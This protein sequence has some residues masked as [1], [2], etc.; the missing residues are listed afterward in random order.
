MEECDRQ[1]TKKIKYIYT[2]Q[3]I[4]LSMIHSMLF[5]VNECDRNHI[6][7]YMSEQIKSHI[8]RLYA[9]YKD[10]TSADNY[11]YHFLMKDKEES[12]PSNFDVRKL[13]DFMG[14]LGYFSLIYKEPDIFNSA[15]NHLLN[16]YPHYTENVSVSIADGSFNESMVCGWGIGL[17]LTKMKRYEN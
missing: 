6:Y 13:F 11:I 3:K 9:N 10:S 16:V 1:L 2:P 14:Y 5:F 4:H 12:F 8:Y 7:P 17:L 15:Y